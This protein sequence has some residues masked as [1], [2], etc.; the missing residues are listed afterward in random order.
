M[1]TE[2]ISRALLILLKTQSLPRA[3]LI[4]PPVPLLSQ[5]DS[6]CPMRVLGSILLF[7]G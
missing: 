3:E 7:V 4:L 2:L 6:L 1:V 5:C